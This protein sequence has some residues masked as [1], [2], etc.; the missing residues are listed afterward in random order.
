MASDRQIVANRRNAAQ[1][2]GPRTAR[3]TLRSRENACHHGLTA[4]TVITSLEEPDD[5]RTFEAG[6][7]DDYAPH[8]VVERE[9]V[10]RL[11]DVRMS[12]AK[13]L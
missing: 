3:A 5:Y 9:L 4:E 6:F 12:L 1:S 10:V 8:G 7:F 11:F 13:S 2:T